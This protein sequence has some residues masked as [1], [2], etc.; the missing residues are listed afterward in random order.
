M[1]SKVSYSTSL[2]ADAVA[3]RHGYR[4]TTST[5][6]G[7]SVVIGERTE[8]YPIS[9]SQED[10]NS[11]RTARVLARQDDWMNAGPLWH[12]SYN[13]LKWRFLCVE[14][15]PPSLAGGC[16]MAWARGTHRG[17]NVL[18]SDWPSER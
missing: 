11:E 7:R 3:Y 5:S 13:G 14:T 17:G 1:H 6:G 9:L 16:G 8:T 18:W 15:R 10:Q 4:L 12:Y 2:I